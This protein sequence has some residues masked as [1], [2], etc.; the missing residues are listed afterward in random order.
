MGMLTLFLKRTVDVLAPSLSEVF[1]RLVRLGSFLSCWRQA[2]VTTI[3]KGP[4]SSSVAN[5]RL[6]SIISPLS[7]AFKHLVSV[8]L[9]RF[10]ERSGVLPSTLFAYRKGLGTC[11][12]VFRMCCIHCKVHWRVGRRLGSYRLI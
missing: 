12:T 7:K 9:G 2:N 5:Y 4:P 6:V 1:R 8:R 10:M 3:P 11:D